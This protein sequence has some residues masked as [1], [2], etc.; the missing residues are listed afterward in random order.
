MVP[1]MS[2]S[3]TDGSQ[4]G[5]MAVFS[6]FH[7][8][9]DR[10][11]RHQDAFYPQMY[12]QVLSR[13]TLNDVYNSPRPPGPPGPP[14]PLP[15]SRH[16]RVFSESQVHEAMVRQFH[17]EYPEYASEYASYQYNEFPN[18]QSC[19]GHDYYSQKTQCSEFSPLCL[20]SRD[21]EYI[22]GPESHTSL[23]SHGSL[24]ALTWGAERDSCYQ[25][26]FE[27][28]PCDLL[29]SKEMPVGKPD[30]GTAVLPGRVHRN[31]HPTASQVEGLWLP[32]G[33]L[34]SPGNSPTASMPSIHPDDENCRP[35]AN[36]NDE[37]KTRKP[38]LVQQLS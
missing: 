13:E 20:K 22:E 36:E 10:F 26:T 15:D 37:P 33:L 8:V 12:H 16:V 1:S 11:R 34:D 27:H 5:Q 23:S 28:G 19:E 21:Y 4:D 17:G 31:G 35:V 6:S 18:F 14:G 7:V 2:P 38:T 3:W 29:D 9:S 30:L 25:D 24:G 32:S